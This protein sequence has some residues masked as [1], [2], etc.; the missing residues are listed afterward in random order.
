MGVLGEFAG[1]G[2]SSFA[3]AGLRRGDILTAVGG[4]GHPKIA[5][6][7]LSKSAIEVPHIIAVCSRS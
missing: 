6:V 7:G 5:F 4:M 2:R 1:N 3:I